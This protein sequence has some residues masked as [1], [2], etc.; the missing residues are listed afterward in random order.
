[1]SWCFPNSKDLFPPFYQGKKISK[2]IQFTIRPMKKSKLRHQFNILLNLCH[3]TCNI[4]NEIHA[5]SS[6]PIRHF[7]AQNDAMLSMIGNIPIIGPFQSKTSLFFISRSNVVTIPY[8]IKVQQNNC[9]N[10]M[11]EE[12]FNEISAGYEI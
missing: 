5:I 12:E 11:I 1:M 8:N 4:Q 3:A 7:N 6:I 9:W 2:T 10:C